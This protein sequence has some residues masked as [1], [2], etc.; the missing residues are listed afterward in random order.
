MHARDE[1]EWKLL[2]QLAMHKLLLAQA[3]VAMA[4]QRVEAAQAEDRALG[5]VFVPAPPKFEPVVYRTEPAPRTPYVD[6]AIAAGKVAVAQEIQD[7]NNRISAFPKFELAKEGAKRPLEAWGESID[8]TDVIKG[9][10]PDEAGN[11]CV[12]PNHVLGHQC[13]AGLND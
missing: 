6:A 8:V 9:C 10:Q 5:T 12:N 7:P 11:E 3:H 13:N 1:Q 4:V 2:K